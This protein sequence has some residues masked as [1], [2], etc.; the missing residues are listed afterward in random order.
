MNIVLFS[1]RLK[2]KTL[3]YKWC[4]DNNAAI[5]VENFIGFLIQHE[6]IDIKNFKALVNKEE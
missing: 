1:E 3:F 6:A 5:C 4:A 2:C